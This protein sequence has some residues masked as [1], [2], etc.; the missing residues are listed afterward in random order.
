MALE[1]EFLNG[2]P[3]DMTDDQRN[4]SDQLPQLLMRTDIGY[5]CEESVEEFIHR[6]TMQNLFNRDIPK[7]DKLE[8]FFRLRVNV[9][10]LDAIEWARKHFIRREQAYRGQSRQIIA[11]EVWARQI[12]NS[13]YSRVNEIKREK[14]LAE[15]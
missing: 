5:L 4:L 6:L 11:S 10:T 2:L 7:K 15:A 9:I 8:S 1:Y 3:K 13:A 12:Y 14:L